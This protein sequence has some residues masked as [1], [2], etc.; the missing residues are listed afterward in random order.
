MPVCDENGSWTWSNHIPDLVQ[1]WLYR[2]L[3]N[4]RIPLTNLNGEVVVKHR[5]LHL[6]RKNQVVLL[7]VIV[8]SGSGEK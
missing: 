2:Q 1:W 3:K 8:D 7:C 6:I 5:V 4:C